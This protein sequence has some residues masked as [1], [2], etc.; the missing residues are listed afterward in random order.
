MATEIRNDVPELDGSTELSFD[1]LC[2][3][4]LTAGRAGTAGRTAA[5]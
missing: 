4:P 5:R 1:G 2:S 3:A